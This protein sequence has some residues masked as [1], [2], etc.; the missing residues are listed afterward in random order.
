MIFNQLAEHI[1]STNSI[2]YKWGSID[3]LYYHLSGTNTLISHHLARGCILH[4]VLKVIAHD[5][6]DKL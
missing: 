2:Q 5:L 3:L 4:Q 6:M 1:K